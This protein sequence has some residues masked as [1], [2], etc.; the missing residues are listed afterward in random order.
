[1]RISKSRTKNRQIAYTAELS[2]YDAEP[3]SRTWL[4]DELPAIINPELEA[5]ALYL[6]FGNWSGGEFVV[7]QKM[8][9]NTA[10]AISAHAGM[11]F[12]PGP[13]EY[14]PKPIFRG[15]NA[16]TVAD[17][18][19]KAGPKTLVVLSNAA[20]NGSLKSTSGLVVPTN[21]DVFED[22][23]GYPTAKLATSV[24]L[25][26]ELDAAEIFLDS[27]FPAPVRAVSNLVRQVGIA[28]DTDTKAG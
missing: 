7:P 20:W 26:E 11:D 9:P 15:S 21:A 18:L 8:S 4:L 3:P 5:V 1:M 19:Q 24:L 6:I 28:I 27:D 13:I 2:E 23:G 17:S 25:A 14:Y 16:V 12:F 10:A 22:K